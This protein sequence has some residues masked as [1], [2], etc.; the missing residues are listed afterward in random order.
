[1]AA[2][3]VGSREVGC[4]QC[5]AV[6]PHLTGCSIEM[7]PEGERQVEVATEIDETVEGESQL[8]VLR[9]SSV[10]ERSTFGRPVRWTRAE[11]R[12]PRVRFQLD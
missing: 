6:E 4:V 10:A 1:M 9:D 2:T 11:P 12:W 7:L 3:E 8:V 5:I